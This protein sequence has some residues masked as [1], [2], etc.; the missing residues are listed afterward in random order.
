MENLTE[1]INIEAK[2]E[3]GLLAT[4][5][6]KMNE[7]LQLRDEKLQQQQKELANKS[8]ET[9]E[10]NKKLLDEVK[11]RKATANVIKRHQQCLITLAGYGQQF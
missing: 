1:R 5:F 4:S 6:N 7:T 11:D 10:T 9:L 3:I 8:K 2:D